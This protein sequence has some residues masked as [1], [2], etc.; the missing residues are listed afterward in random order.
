MTSVA[1]RPLTLEEFLALPEP[2]VPTEFVSGKVVEK[3]MPTHTHSAMV[4][5]LGSLL[6]AFLVKHRLGF[7]GPEARHLHRGE[8]RLYL[9]DLEVFLARRTGEGPEERRPDIA[10]EV[11]S[12]G[13]RPASIAEKVT[14]YLRAGVPLIWVIDPE[15][16]TLD[17][18]MPGKAAVTY[19]RGDLVPGAPVLPEFELDTEEFFG[20]VDVLL[21]SWSLED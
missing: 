20:L 2:E 3:P 11:L 16:R 21:T 10:I 8:E 13:D 1:A 18:F 7:V 4:Q 14:F 15:D 9:P 19:R 6:M 12:P 17:A 5:A